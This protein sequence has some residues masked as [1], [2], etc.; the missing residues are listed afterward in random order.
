MVGFILLVLVTTAISIALVIAIARSNMSSPKVR[1]RRN[2]ELKRLDAELAA[3]RAL[4]AQA[5]ESASPRAKDV[6]ERLLAERERYFTA[7]NGAI[8]RRWHAYNPGPG[9]RVRT[10]ES[11]G[12]SVLLF[13]RAI[14][15]CNSWFRFD[16]TG[17]AS[18]KIVGSGTQTTRVLRIETSE[19]Y[20]DETVID[21]SGGS[22]GMRDS[23][24][25]MKTDLHNTLI[26]FAS[27]RP[28]QQAAVEEANQHL[29]RAQ[30]DHH[31][32]TELS[33]EFRTVLDQDPTLVALWRA[34]QH[35]EELHARYVELR[36]DLEFDE[37]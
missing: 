30:A 14:N 33:D 32:L 9:R 13:E 1:V 10:L 6:N 34:Q 28:R 16:Q 37:E 23:A 22:M 24:D 25:R 2:A 7:V 15:V 35:Q 27:D 26:D 31:R 29:Y 4:T 8:Q 18:P 19:G 12:V 3:A 17:R 5:L 20:I 11:G 36:T 21:V